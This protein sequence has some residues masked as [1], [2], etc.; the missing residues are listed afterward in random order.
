[1]GAL[2]HFTISAITSPQTAGQ[3][4]AITVTAFDANNNIDTN[5]DANGNKVNL[6]STGTLVYTNPSPAFT[7]GVLANQSVSITNTG[8]FTITAT[9]TG[10]NSS[11][12]GVSNSFTVNPGPVTAG[13]SSVVASP[14]SVVADGS[15]ISTITVTLKDGFGNPVS[16]KTVSLAALG[17]SSTIATLSGTSNASGQATFSAKDSVVESVTYRATDVTDANLPITQTATVNFTV[18]PVS[19]TASTVVANP[20]QVIADGSSNSTIAVPL[21]DGVN[22]LVSGETVALTAHE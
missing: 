13:T 9:G 5:F 7:S 19:T 17:G 16:G 15:S 20:T 14:T 8:S 2:D 21:K 22:R 3:A 11:I 10:N 1:P 12:T 6:T 18:G 4:F